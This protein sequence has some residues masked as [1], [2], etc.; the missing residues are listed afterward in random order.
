MPTDE[1]LQ[2][3]YRL[4]YYLTYLRLPPIYLICV[5]KRTKNLFILAGHNEEIEV[6]I[7]PD[8]R[9]FNEPG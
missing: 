8:G 6:E 9:C 4:S 1:Q 3:L 7:T 2:G 5:D